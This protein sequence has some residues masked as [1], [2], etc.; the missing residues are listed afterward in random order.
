MPALPGSKKGSQAGP[1]LL[2]PLGPIP[3][4]QDRP[5]PGI[6]RQPDRGRANTMPVGVR[7]AV[8]A[9]AFANVEVTPGWPCVRN[10][11][12]RQTY[13]FSQE[14]KFFPTEFGRSPRSRGYMIL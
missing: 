4:R 6:K 12:G 3:S 1:L 2:Y 5:T 10:C 13:G 14:T 9:Q 11:P 8:A 7:F